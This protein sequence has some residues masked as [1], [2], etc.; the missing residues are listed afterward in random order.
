MITPSDNLNRRIV[1]RYLRSQSPGCSRPDRQ[2][3]V[4]H[5]PVPEPHIPDDIILECSSRCSLNARELEQMLPAK[6]KYRTGLVS[7]RA[8]ACRH[9]DQQNQVRGHYERRPQDHRH[10]HGEYRGQRTQTRRVF[11][12]R[13]GY[14]KEWGRYRPKLKGYGLWNRA[15]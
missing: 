6:L 1:A 15:G 10:H 13:C 2:A 11:R 9:T 4:W 3:L 12:R 7:N 5:L 14:L 8:S